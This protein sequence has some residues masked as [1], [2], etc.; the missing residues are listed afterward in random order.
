VNEDTSD[1][2]I[3]WSSGQERWKSINLTVLLCALRQS[4]DAKEV[5]KLESQD[6]EVFA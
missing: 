2:V 5:R 3:V 6:I 4:R 1:S